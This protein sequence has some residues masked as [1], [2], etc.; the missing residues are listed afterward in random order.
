M[1]L[2]V[3]TVMRVL[4]FLL[5]G[6]FAV[7]LAIL[8][9]VWISFDANRAGNSLVQYFRDQYQ[10]TLRLGE[11]PRLRML[12][13]PVLELRKL[14]LSEP[15]KNEVFASAASVRLDLQLM[16][17]LLRQT[18]VER[19]LLAKAD[20]HLVRK[21]NGDWNAGDLAA[22]GQ[23]LQE[24]PW[25]AELESLDLREAR[26][27]VDDLASA[28]HLE[29]SELALHTGSLRDKI[30]GSFTLRGVAL[31]ED[32]QG[33]EVTLR[34]EGRYVLADRL[35]EG[36]L[37]QLVVHLDGD[38]FGLKGATGVAQ[39]AGVIWREGG[40]RFDMAG[41]Q[42]SLRGALGEQALDFSAEFPA[43]VREAKSLQGKDWKA[44]FVARARDHETRLE[45]QMPV[46]SP[47]PEGFRAEGAQFKLG[48]RDGKHALNIELA[49]PVNVD[50]GEGR[51]AV[52]TVQGKLAAESPWLRNGKLSLPLKGRIGWQMGAAG[53]TATTDADL[54]L[55][56][57]RDAL[58]ASASLQ[59][60]W[61]LEG[62]LDLSSNR[63]DLDAFFIP[64]GLREASASAL[65]GLADARLNGKLGLMQLKLGG[66]LRFSAIK[67]P[68]TLAKG[69]LSLPEL[70]AEL[71]TGQLQGS[72][73]LV[74][75]TGALDFKG[76]F[77]EVALGQLARDLQ[78]R[79]PFS[80]DLGGSFAFTGEYKA[81]S[82][83]LPTLQGALRWKL[84]NGALQGFDLARSL[85]EFRP[86][87]RAGKATARTPGANEV[88][89]VSAASSR[90]VFDHGKLVAENF[91]AA[92]DWLSLGGT[93]EGSL[94]S[95]EID[96]ALGAML[97]SRI[98]GT[99]ARDL[100]DLRAPTPLPI[101]LKG[102]PIN[103][104]VRFEPG[105]KIAA[106][107]AP[108]KAA[109]KATQR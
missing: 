18:V 82:P 94:D 42:M 73:N 61:P 53:Q 26:L 38:A 66:G 8:L 78:Q 86:Q 90:F 28:R 83:F 30:P 75:A 100:A 58:Q 77:G 107:A 79:L 105:L 31:G 70:Q 49:S 5:G 89:P 51:I 33:D 12:P 81:G 102:K 67:A 43:L 103:P 84:Q 6:F 93:G 85:R 39:A 4:G 54:S 34:A 88:T 76:E 106:Q 11:A 60:L 74:T 87:I 68:F 101:R 27:S 23:A 63:L 92:N 35:T 7:S 46:L 44:R 36:R 25:H 96:F 22:S 37:D 24:L 99:A 57:G 29:L 69:N 71:Y 20:L 1:S 21:A 64:A 55:N 2:R 45:A 47:T 17:L 65:P 98:T 19:V 32:S 56:Q 104:D 72:L 80:G 109:S 15:G 40:R 50:F 97:L 3:A 108:A 9:F 52:P 13:F 95:G 16:P 48:H 14:S 59:G 10:R 62:R 91:Q 41:G